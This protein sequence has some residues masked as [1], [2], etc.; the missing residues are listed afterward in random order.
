MCLI[1]PR[2]VRVYIRH[3]KLSLTH[4]S[5]SFV[6][7]D[8]V[9]SSDTYFD[10]IEIKSESRRSHHSALNFKIKEFIPDMLK[11]VE[12]AG[13]QG[14]SIWLTA[15]PIKDHGFTLYESAFRDPLALRIWLA[16]RSSSL[17]VCLWSR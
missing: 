3:Q 15:L 13:Q 6:T 8:P 11:P 2:N 9:Y 16:A 10:Q 17:R 7:Q 5:T 12:M 4:W 14:A 1:L